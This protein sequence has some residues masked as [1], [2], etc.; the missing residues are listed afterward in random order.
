MNKEEFKKLHPK[1]KYLIGEKFFR[2]TVVDF[3]KMDEKGKSIWLCECQCGNFKEIRSSS[4][5]F[6]STNSCGCLAIENHPKKHGLHK[7]SEYCCWTDMQGRC[8]NKNCKAYKNYGGR[9]I[10]VCE[11]WLNFENFYKDMGKRPKGFT[12]DRIDNHGNYCKENC[13]W[14]T[15]SE[16]NR[17]HR[18][19]INITFNG[20]T[21]CLKDW[22][23]ELALS[24]SILRYRLHKLN[25][26]VEQSFKKSP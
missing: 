5:C 8:Y 1:A 12:L 22:A 10:K 18:R 11:E 2:L 4:L 14:S 23:K 20:K 7:S 26:T 13:K 19:N 21:Q 25:L 24:Y 6:G 9:G 15:R 3:S 16:Q 17:N